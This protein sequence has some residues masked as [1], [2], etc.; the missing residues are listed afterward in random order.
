[1]GNKIIKCIKYLAIP[2][3]KETA[4]EITAELNPKPAKI[5]RKSPPLIKILPKK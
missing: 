1:M 3:L 5:L 2:A 4:I